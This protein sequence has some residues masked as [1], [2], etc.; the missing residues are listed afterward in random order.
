MAL[1]FWVASNLMLS[2]RDRLAL[3]KVDDALLRLHMEL[4]FIAGVRAGGPPR[5][6]R[7]ILG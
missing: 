4:R 7:A 6:A 1:S 2:A 3:F 5:P